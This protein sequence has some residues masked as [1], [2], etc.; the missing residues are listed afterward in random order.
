MIPTYTQSVRFSTHPGRYLA[1]LSFF[2]CSLL[3]WQPLS[4]ATFGLGTYPD[5][6]QELITE[7]G[8]IPLLHQWQ[9]QQMANRNALRYQAVAD[10]SAFV[11]CYTGFEAGNDTTYC[12]GETATLDGGFVSY[13]GSGGTLLLWEIASGGSGSFA[14]NGTP[15]GPSANSLF[16]FSTT[17]NSCMG[18]PTVTYVPGASDTEVTLRLTANP[19]DI[20]CD[21]EIDEVTLYFDPVQEAVIQVDVENTTEIAAATSTSTN[22]VTMCSDDELDLSVTNSLVNG[23]QNSDLPFLQYTITTTGTINGLPAADVEE[24][25]DFN[26]TWSNLTLELPPMAGAP[27]TATISIVTFYDRNTN[28]MIDA[29]ECEGDAVEIEVTVLPQ[30]QATS[31]VI[32]GLSFCEDEIATIRITGS[33][34]STVTYRIDLGDGNGFGADQTT[35]I[36]ALG[37][38]T[39]ITINTAGLGGNTITFELLSVA[40]STGAPCPRTLTE[41]E[42]ITVLER[43]SGTISFTSINNECNDVLTEASLT[44]TTSDP[45]GMYR[46]FVSRQVF[47]GPD[48]GTNDDPLG[49]FDVVTSGGTATFMADLGDTDIDG[50]ISIFT[51]DSL[52]SLSTMPNCIATTN[53][54]N[55]IIFTEQ[56]EEFAVLGVSINNGAVQEANALSGLSIQVCDDSELDLSILDYG[57]SLIPTHDERLEL[58]ITDD[59]DLLGFGGTGTYIVDILDIFFWSLDN[60][61]LDIPNSATTSENIQI[62]ATPFFE[63]LDPSM[64]NGSECSDSSIVI[65]I[66]ILPQI[67]AVMTVSDTEICENDEVTFTI[68]SNTEGTARLVGGMGGATINVPVTTMSG[69]DYVGTFTTDP[70]TMDTSFTFVDF[71]RNVPPTCETEFNQTIDIE[72][73]PRP[74]TA[75]M[76]LG[77]DTLCSGD[78]T[79]LLLAATGGNG[80]GYQFRV[81]IDGTDFN[82]TVM[83]SDTMIPLPNNAPG[84]YPIRLRRTRNAGG[85]QC[86]F[87]GPDPRDTLYVEDI[88]DVTVT[89]TFGGAMGM[90]EL[91]SDDG[92]VFD[93]DTMCSGDDITITLDSDVTSITGADLYY[94]FEVVQ[95]PTGT[96]PVGIDTV[97]VPT[98]LLPVTLPAQQFISTFS[99][100]VDVDLRLTPLFLN[101]ADSSVNC[102]GTPVDLELFIN[103]SPEATFGGNQTI[104]AG[105]SALLDF[106][107]PNGGSVTLEIVSG[108]DDN[109]PMG[110]TDTVFFSP[111]GEGFYNTGG[112]DTTTI[113]RVGN[114]T[115]DTTMNPICTNTN[116][117][118]VTVTVVDLPDA[119]FTDFEDTICEGTDLTL[120]L[121]GTPNAFVF[122]GVDSIG[123][124]GDDVVVVGLDDMGM[125]SYNTGGLFVNEEVRFDID[126]VSLDTA[127]NTCLNTAPDYLDTLFGSFEIQLFESPIGTI[128]PTEPL[129]LGDTAYLV[130]DVTSGASNADDTYTIVVNDSTYTVEDGETF[131]VRGDLLTATTLFSLTSMSQDSFPFCQDTITGAIDTVSVI[132]EEVPAVTATL[133]Y[134]AQVE[135][136]TAAAIF[137][138]TVCAGGM[139]DMSLVGTPAGG[140]VAGDPLYYEIVIDDADNLIGFGSGPSTLLLSAAAANTV[141]DGFLPTT[142][143]NPGPGPSLIEVSFLPYYETAPDMMDPT[144]GDGPD[145]ANSCPGDT[146]RFRTLILPE[147]QADFFSMDETICED[148]MATVEVTGSPNTE[149]TVFDGGNVFTVDVDGSGMGSFNTGALSS[150]TT[151][152]ITGVAT[153]GQDPACSR[154]IFGGPTVTITVTPTPVVAFDL[155]ASDLEVCFD[156]APVVAITGTADA[157]VTY[158]V[159]E[160]MATPDTSTIMLDGSGNATIP[161]GALEEDA[162]V[163]LIAVVTTGLMP[164][165]PDSLE[166]VTVNIEVRDIPS[167]TLTNSGPVCFGDSIDITFTAD[168]ALDLVGPFRAVVR[169]PGIMGTT[170]VGGAN[171]A[172]FDS[173]VSGVSFLRVGDEGLYEILALRDLGANPMDGCADPNTPIMGISSLLIIEETPNLQSTVTAEVGV[174]GLD[175]MMGISTFN[176]IVCNGESLIAAFSSLTPTSDPMGDNNPLW[177]EI[178]VIAD[179]DD[180]LGDVLDGADTVAGSPFVYPLADLDFNGPLNNPGMGNSQ[181]HVVLTPYFEDGDDDSSRSMAE[182][183]G[184]S[185]TFNITILPAI[186]ASI[187]L[188]ATDTTV[189]NGDEIKVVVTGS[190]GGIVDFATSGMASPTASPITLTTG[191]DTIFGTA[192]GSGPAEVELTNITVISTI[193]PVT[194]VCMESLMDTVD[195]TINPIPDGL[196][197]ADPAGPICNGDS[198]A[199]FFTGNTVT[200]Q[201]GSIGLE[202]GPYTLTINGQDTVVNVMNDTAFVFDVQLFEDSTFTLT[203]IVNNTTGCF[204][205][206]MLGLWSVTVEVEEIPAGEIIATNEAM[207]MDT[208]SDG[209]LDTLFICTGDSL[210]LAINSFN[211]TPLVGG[212]ENHV[213]V[214]FDNDQDYYGLGTS[215][216][217]SL[218]VDD[219]EDTFSTRFQNL[220]NDTESSFLTVTYF[221][222]DTVGTGFS[223]MECTGITDSFY[224]LISPNPITVDVDTM[225]CSGDIVDIDLG[226]GITNGV[227]GTTFTYTTSVDPMVIPAPDDRTVAS[228]DRLVDTFTN[229][230]GEDFTV[231]YTVTPMV[232]GCAGNDYDLRVLIKPEPVL[233]QDLQDTIC[234]DSRINVRFDEISGIGNG[235]TN[236]RLLDR[237]LGVHDPDFFGRPDNAPIDTIGNRGIIRNDTFTN[238]TNDFQ[239]V[240]YTILPISDDGCDGDTLVFD[241]WIAPEPKVDDIS[242]QVC[243]GSRLDYDIIH[244]LVLNQIGDPGLVEFERTITPGAPII[245]FDRFDEV[246]TFNINGRQNITDGFCAAFPDIPGCEVGFV[247][248]SLLGDSLINTGT[249]LVSI[250]YEVVVEDTLGCGTNS[251]VLQVDIAEE[252]D[253]SLDPEG[254]TDLC[255]GDPI[256]LNTTFDGIG[257]PVYT[258]SFEDADPGVTSVVIDT[259]NASGSSVSIDG[260]GSGQVTIRVEVSTGNGCSATATRVVTIGSPPASTGINGFEEPCAGSVI[261]TTYTLVG[262]NPNNDFAWTLSDPLA[263]NILGPTNGP[264]LTLTWNSAGGPYT[265]TVTETVPGGANCSITH[266][267]NVRVVDSPSADFSFTIQPGNSL[268]VDFF[269]AAQGA[270][271]SYDWDFGDGMGTSIDEDPSYVYGAAGTYPVQLITSHLCGGAFSRD[272]IVKDVTVGPTV[273]CQILNI[274]QGFNFVSLTVAPFDSSLNSIFGPYA[275]ISQVTSFTTMPVNWEP[276]GGG[277]NTLNDMRRGFGYFVFSDADVDVP[278]CGIPEDGT[279]RRMLNPGTNYVGPADTATISADSFFTN[280]V[281]N[282][283]LV[284]AYTFTPTGFLTYEPGGGGFN[285]MTEVEAGRGYVVITSTAVN[286]GSWRVADNSEEHEF[287]FGYVGGEDFDPTQLIEVVNATGE[288]VSSFSANEEGLY[289]ASA[290]FGQLARMDGSFAE[291]LDEGE[292][293]FFRHNGVTIDAG[294][295]YAGGYRST[296]LDLDFTAVEENLPTAISVPSLKVSPNPLATQAQI[297]LKVVEAGSYT[298][299]ILDMN[300]RLVHTALSEEQL[301][302]GSYN[303][304]MSAA[305][306]APG[307]Y[308]VVITKDGYLMPDLSLRLVKQ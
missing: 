96:L 31:A 137:E 122:I 179:P 280:L 71:V 106:T 138:D 186:S 177:V 268:G 105:D 248:D 146:V 201:A 5:A 202:D 271:L 47:G 18:C 282:N 216:D 277:F 286:E 182:C 295:H 85:L 43:P 139:F 246:V 144:V 11:P 1:I 49:P 243:S 41:T 209:I 97:F 69:G 264:S 162:V 33:P 190:V 90:V 205:E 258:Y 15:V 134:D 152:Q 32:G 14:L 27:E 115:T 173:I 267:L 125:G 191:V 300:G 7:F 2:I 169:G 275:D 51:L 254:T 75:T 294:M 10:Q 240:T 78:S 247:Q 257:T 170:G 221:I 30:A 112:L 87:S 222:E 219:F 292:A 64:L 263:G 124:S 164:N 80:T 140:S 158:S 290:V 195:I 29:G 228:S 270:V 196:I 72:V 261:P 116:T 188:M 166:N 101:T 217:I 227:V 296:R 92:P 285:T 142:I 260:T 272:T 156:T 211:S 4:A 56:A 266:T 46:L 157:E 299:R 23:G 250:F 22:Q 135:V 297:E 207:E 89:G 305:R 65:D 9:Q 130:F 269:E 214:T 39:D 74:I 198:T 19:D 210:N 136:V 62:V 192:I 265:L 149:I 215:G 251:F 208:I 235:S 253:A 236:F 175:N 153:V 54:S 99:V 307:M 100:P 163:E 38:N 147:L 26:L 306:M 82:Y 129:C 108:D 121:V 187:D 17:F 53:G 45:D 119:A 61:Q 213:Y 81:R 197:Y 145:E 237:E 155:G 204:Q 70:L 230:S 293:Y 24:A 114:I 103:P 84:I 91:D 301:L 36:P 284:F 281:D 25:A 194:K 229:V 111:S 141:L 220:T 118:D 44:Y 120:E 234:S 308:S 113:F 276:G 131:Q 252:A 289:Q 174:I 206:D 83:G 143:S 104:C 232:G 176:P 48:D 183:A 255:S 273:N 223:G 68:T 98:A 57:A 77:Q 52:Q 239:S 231:T 79:F 73:E 185:L 42:V 168:P 304:N 218:E 150:T 181:L 159:T 165:C 66:E 107:G 259:I 37:S 224:V 249:G 245:V 160:G 203:K 288:V 151:Y 94:I 128:T 172:V 278:V 302:P 148:S 123:S 34:N 189:C 16:N 86:T 200:F 298:L 193:G 110:T 93:Q 167:G 50:V 225:Y 262:A 40:Y 242:V 95:D 132:V 226:I 6:E 287:I 58:V 154:V 117:F 238:L 279:Y 102:V 178:E 241:L 161:V 20:T 8:T 67:D 12:E 55:Q 212:G 28:G 171:S 184:P 256:V 76:T 133:T 180:L 244:D 63:S 88:P 109:L 35:M 13:S 291:G 127:G 199:I 3:A 126:S 21:T 233:F 283:Q 59:L 60:V 274:R 303:F